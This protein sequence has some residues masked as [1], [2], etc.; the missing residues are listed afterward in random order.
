MA[1]KH[2][3]QYCALDEAMTAPVT[4][5]TGLVWMFILAKGTRWGITRVKSHFCPQ[6]HPP[7]VSYL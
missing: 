3:L 6:P 2:F 5:I 1:G 4:Q 7:T